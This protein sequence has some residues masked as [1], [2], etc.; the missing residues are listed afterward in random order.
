VKV[1]NI[2]LLIIITILPLFGCHSNKSAKN[3]DNKS[4]INDFEL[5]QE[6]PD[7]ETRVKITSPRAIIDPRN[8]DIEIYDS[9]IVILNKN[10]I[11]FKVQS[12]NSSL[13]NL[14]N[15]IRLFNN[16]NILFL[17]KSDYIIRT[18]SLNWDLNAS[19]IDINNPLNIY[20]DNTKINATNGFYNIGSSL[21][22]IDNS[23][24]NR[25]INNSE[26]IE[27]Y[28]VEI[29]SDY[30]KWFKNNNKLVFTSNDKQVETTIKFLL[31]K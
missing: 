6:N 22:K 27:E 26:G 10:G 20:F 24:F 7:N 14:T 23:N 12:G 31:T 18:N 1:F 28:E 21:L 30:A 19:V 13:N 15:N 11:D 9:S 17:E 5:L 4:Y 16:V 25:I 3:I 8:S 2:Y 29:L